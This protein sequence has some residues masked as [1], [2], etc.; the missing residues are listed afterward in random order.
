[1]TLDSNL[2]RHMWLVGP[3]LNGEVR[4]LKLQEA[5]RKQPKVGLR[6]P[7]HMNV[8]S[9]PILLLMSFGANH[10]VFNVFIPWFLLLHNKDNDGLYT[11]VL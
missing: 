2:S 6:V 1:M 11:C 3:V 4:N 8:G 5:E 10:K 7:A 9:N